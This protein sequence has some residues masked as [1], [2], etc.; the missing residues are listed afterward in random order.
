MEYQNAT[1]DTVYKWTIRTLYTTA[2]ALNVWYLLEQYRQTPEAKTLLSRA[3][4][5]KQRF[6]KTMRDTKK[7][8]RMADETLVEAWIVVDQAEKEG[9]D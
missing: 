9:K 4:R 1:S 8:R 5:I 3:E 6:T 7:F 2:I